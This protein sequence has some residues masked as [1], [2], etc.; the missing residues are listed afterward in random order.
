M[1]KFASHQGVN[2]RIIRPVIYNM[3][4]QRGMAYY[5]AS[6]YQT[7]ASKKFATDGSGHHLMQN[8]VSCDKSDCTNKNCKA[9]CTE[10]IKSETTG[11]YT[12]KP[13]QNTTSEYL[14][15]TDIGGQ[16]KDQHFVKPTQKPTISLDDLK[17]M[18]E[19]DIKPHKEATRYSQVSSIFE[20]IKD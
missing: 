19:D 18:T 10:A 3:V 11:H 5:F 13:P 16:Q 12:H 15:G 8:R 2:I 1:F 20:K 4:D 17:N 6:K 7:A 14:S 9:P